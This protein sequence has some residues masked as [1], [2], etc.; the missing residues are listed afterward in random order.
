MCAKWYAQRGFT[1]E[2]VRKARSWYLRFIPECGNLLDLGCGRGEFLGNF[3]ELGLDVCGVDISPEASAFAK[4]FTVEV[5]DV[6]NE[7]LPF[8]DNTFDVLYSKSFVEHLHNPGRYLE[9]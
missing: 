8:D 4:G 1:T 6:E 3:Q 9:E 7:P 2:S 5:C